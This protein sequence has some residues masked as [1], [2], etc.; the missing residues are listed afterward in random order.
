[1][2]QIAFVDEEV[3]KELKKLSSGDNQEELFPEH[4]FL[5]ICIK[6]GIS[7]EYLKNFT[8]IDIIKI[9]LSTISDNKNKPH[10]ATQKDIDEFLR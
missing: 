1:M 8:Y 4:A 6:A 10:K 5:S 2:P 7:Y 9:I 3:N